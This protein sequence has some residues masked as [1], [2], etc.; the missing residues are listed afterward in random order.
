MNG[1]KLS[2]LNIKK[3]IILPK[4]I[5]G[6]SAISLK[7]LTGSFIEL[8]KMISQSFIKIERQ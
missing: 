5:W 3:L 6:F 2:K 8:D 1:K 7:T 4:I